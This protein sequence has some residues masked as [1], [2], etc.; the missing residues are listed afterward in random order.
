MRRF[1]LPLAAVAIAF[2]GVARAEDAEAKKVIDKAI[3]AH[4]G[5]DAL[6]KIKDKSAIVKGK[7]N[8]KLMGGIDATMEMFAGDKKFKQE[9][10]FSIM[11]IDFHQV[12]GY[13]GKEVLIA[14]NG[15]VVQTKTGK[16]LDPIKETIHA[17]EM[18]GLA[19]L[20]DKDLEF[21]TVG[22]S[23]VGDQEVIG[24]KVSKKG[25][26]DV[27]LFFDKKTGLLAKT[28]SRGLDFQTN[29][30]VNDERILHDYKKLDGIMKPTRVTMNRDGKKFLEMEITEQKYVDKLDENT[31][32][33]P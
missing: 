16:D 3:K 11:G 23:K 17:E 25:H 2:A 12:V 7:M 22:E 18:A 26:K 19:L 6:A 9:L 33:K 20:G 29:E 21:A 28:E 27:S 10:K 24:I 32:V 5:A 1:V 4:G 30:E 8:I 15:N 31:F 13:D 14:L